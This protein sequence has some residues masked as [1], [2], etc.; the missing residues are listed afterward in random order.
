MKVTILQTDIAWAQPE[1]N[2]KKAERLI[3]N[4]PESDIYILPEMWNTGF[5]TSPHHTADISGNATFFNDV[6]RSFE[7]MRNIAIKRNCA[8]SGSIAVKTNDGKF[9]NRHYF[10][11]P[12]TT[13]DC[14]DKHHLF[15]YGG[16]DTHFTAGT[17]RTV[18]EYK[19]IRFMLATC[20]D[21]RFPTWLRYK[22]DYDAMIVAANWPASRQDAWHIL[23]RARAIENQCY[24]LAANRTGQDEYCIYN[25]NSAIIDAYGKTIIQCC[26][27]EE[28]AITGEMDMERL[29]KFRNKFRVLDDRD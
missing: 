20:Y 11:R 26:D 19:G 8:I 21:L 3:L 1:L 29:R 27:A 4:A 14:Y 10:V 16:E 15:T 28:Q 6:N 23:L 2:E 18:A 25:G 9:F 13:F 12:D 22:G 5:I 24:V 17:G 7:W